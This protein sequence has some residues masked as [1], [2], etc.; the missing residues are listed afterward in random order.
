M[1]LITESFHLF[2]GRADFCLH[3]IKQGSTESVA[4]ISEVEIIDFA[5]E[6]VIAVPA[7]RNETM[8]MGVPF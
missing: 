2:K 1:F 8:D 7:F 5:P 6:T 4:Q 3:L